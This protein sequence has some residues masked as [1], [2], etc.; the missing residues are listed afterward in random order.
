MSLGAS[1]RST[2]KAHTFWL[3]SQQQR[4]T[5]A[6]SRLPLS[7]KPFRTY[8]TSPS[9]MQVSYPNRFV[10]ILR[11]RPRER[12]RSARFGRLREIVEG[13]RLRKTND[14]IRLDCSARLPRRLAT[15]SAALSHPHLPREKDSRRLLRSAAVF[16]NRPA[17]VGRTGCLLLYVEFLLGSTCTA[18]R[19]PERHNDNLFV[20]TEW[21]DRSIR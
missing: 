21:I 7:N 12:W 9:T 1:V 19:R 17:V 2:A 18:D 20:C 10:S 5:T 13:H 3:C 16:R 15:D 6:Q 8:L 4:D 14:R 11:S